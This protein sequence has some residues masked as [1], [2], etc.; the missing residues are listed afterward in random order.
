MFRNP[1]SPMPM[2]SNK[3][4]ASIRHGFLSDPIVA[5]RFRR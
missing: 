3:T 5:E 2:P 4:L 1:P